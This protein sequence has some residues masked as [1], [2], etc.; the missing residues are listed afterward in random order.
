MGGFF[1]GMLEVGCLR[2]APWLMA[3]GFST[4]TLYGAHGA[5]GMP[6]SSR[7]TSPDAV[8]YNRPVSTVPSSA[9]NITDFELLSATLVLWIFVELELMRSLL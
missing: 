1:V 8:E 7:H 5:E 6:S 4:A 9:T 3:A 2:E